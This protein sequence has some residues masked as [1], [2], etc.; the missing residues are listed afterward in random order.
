MTDDKRDKWRR[1]PKVSFNHKDIKK[2]MRKVETATIKHAH[3]FVIKRWGNVREVQRRVVLWILAVGLLIAATGLQLMWYQQGYRTTA[4]GTDGTYAEAVLGPVDTLNP[5]FASSSAEKAT[6]YL[7]FSRLLNYDNTGHLGYDLVSNIRVNDTK[8]VY[9]ISIR[10]DVKWHDGFDLT[11]KDVIFTIGLIQNQNTRSTISG[12]TDINAKLIN[13]TTF[14]LTLK[15]TYAAFEHALTFPILPKHILGEVSPSNIR[16]N[17]FSQ[18]PIGSGPFKL[19]FVQD[20]DSSSGHKIIYM[21]KNEDYYSGIVKLSRFQLHIYD[22]NDAILHALSINE[23]NA[24]AD[25]SIFDIDSVDTKR[26]DV[27]SKSIQ[28]GVYAILNTQSALLKDNALRRVLQQATNTNEIRDKFSTKVTSLDLPFTNGQLTGNVPTVMPFDQ[29]K[30]IKMLDDNGWK[31]NGQNVREKD[32]KPLK[33]SIVTIKDDELEKVLELLVGQWRA[34]GIV[35]DTKVIDLSDV[36]QNAVQNVLQSRNYDVLLYRLNIG[37]DPDVYAYWHSSQISTQGYNFANYSNVISDDAL[38]S[39]R[40]RV[41]PALRNAKYITFA[42]QWIN[43]VPAIGLYQS[44][45]QY[46]N[47]NNVKSFNGS[48]VLVSPVDRYGDVVNWSVGN[49]NVYKTP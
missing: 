35:I 37:A 12:W 45:A 10:P 7:M 26:Y 40:T 25:L 13:D 4:T 48:N 47:S 16:E 6:S 31:L 33:L 49:K 29:G 30:A 32:G 42:K 41:E 21:A 9:T 44:T 1:L 24:A 18:D 23:V 20:A 15:S 8:T 17:S 34:I 38:S 2:R 3:K 28:S 39:A 43:D 27:S 22:T 36:S 46:V 11:A 14:E 19:R 5:L